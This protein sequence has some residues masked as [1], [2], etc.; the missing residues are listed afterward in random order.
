MSTFHPVSAGR[1]RPAA[2]ARSLGLSIAV[3]LAA[4]TASA[5]DHAADHPAAPAGLLPEAALEQ[6][7][8]GNKCFLEDALR[9]PDQSESHRVKVAKGQRPFAIV[10]TCADSRVAPEIYF[11]QGLGG[12]FVIRNAGH[13]LG[14]HVL[15]SIEYAVAHL[16]VPL[17]V[18]VG[19]ERCGAVSAAVGGGVMEG[20]V[21]DIVE[22]I[23]PAVQAARGLPGDAVANTVTMH[24]QLTAKALATSGP[25]IAD[26]VMAGR[27]M[28]KA[29]HYD[30]DS[31]RVEL[32][33]ALPEA[34]DA[35]IAGH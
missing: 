20:H 4:H 24:S 30:L 3:L 8:A 33:P 12:I 16:G 28:V 9:H 17:I 32:L 11:D 15:G 21:W 19:H 31:G 13:V 27:V 2:A 22:A 34:P 23:K 18:V 1:L 26:A 25:I 14:A 35:S 29:A 5:A 6:L 7:M 10:L